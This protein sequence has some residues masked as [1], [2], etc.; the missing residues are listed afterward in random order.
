M[1]LRM[2]VILMA[3]AFQVPFT[4]KSPETLR[5]RY[6]K[7]IS[8]TFLVRPGIFVTADYGPSGQICGLSIAPKSGSLVASKTSASTID[9]KV[10]DEIADE[11]VPNSERGKFII[12]TFDD[13]V[14]IKMD[15]AL[16]VADDSSCAGVEENW[17]RIGIF[18]SNAGVKGASRYETIRWK[19]NECDQN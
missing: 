11:L 10:L 15:G 14:C 2:G 17:Q 4:A 6:G 16:V 18:R 9:D 13:F 1:W 7:P 8:E 12:A 3:V 5:Q 19:R